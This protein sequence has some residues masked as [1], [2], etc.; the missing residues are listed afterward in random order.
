MA[1]LKK[2]IYYYFLKQFNIKYDILYAIL[3]KNYLNKGTFK[4]WHVYHFTI[5]TVRKFNRIFEHSDI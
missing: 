5:Q 3:T 1:Y 4:Q 2:Y